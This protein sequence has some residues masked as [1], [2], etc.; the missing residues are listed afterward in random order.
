VAFDGTNCLVAWAEG[1]ES[2]DIYCARVATD[3]TVLDT[4]GIPVSTAAGEQRAPA[5][6]FDGVNFLIIW[7]DKRNG[8]WDV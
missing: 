3:G 5:I 6:A 1:T 7:Q 2:G 8:D 4:A